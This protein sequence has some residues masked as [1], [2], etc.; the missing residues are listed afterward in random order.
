MRADDPRLL[1]IP[2][3]ERRLQALIPITLCFRSFPSP[4]RQGRAAPLAGRDHRTNKTHCTQQCSARA[5]PDI[6][7]HHRPVIALN[8]HRIAPIVAV[9]GCH[10]NSSKKNSYHTWACGQPPHGNQPPTHITSTHSRSRSLT[11]L[12]RQITPPTK[13]GHAPPSKKS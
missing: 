12:T 9:G 5:A 3:S 11:E 10:G 1:G 13:N 8:F 6:E 4:P 7:G 2:R